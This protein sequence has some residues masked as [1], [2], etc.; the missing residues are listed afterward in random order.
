LP[1]EYF[2]EEDRCARARGHVVACPLAHC[3]KKYKIS[4][5]EGTL[6]IFPTHSKLLT[7]MRAA[8]VL[9][10]AVGEYA[11]AAMGRTMAKGT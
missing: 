4:R 8:L 2:R 5:V 1:G 10:A 11:V 9:A 3:R 6:E 7:T